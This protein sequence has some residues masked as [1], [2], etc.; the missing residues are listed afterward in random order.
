[1]EFDND[2]KAI[3]NEGS[4]LFLPSISVDCVIFGFHN[5]ELKVLL[6][7]MKQAGVYALPGGFILKGE[8][9]DTAAI[10]VLKE[11]TGLDNIFLQQFYTFGEPDRSDKKLHA[12]LMKKEGIVVDKTNWLLQ[13]FI[14]IGYYALVD[15]SAVSPKH[16]AL[17]ITCDWHTLDAVTTL[18]MDHNFILSKALQTLQQQISYLPIGYNLLPLKFTMPELQKLYETILNKSLDRRNF[19]RR[20]LSY[21]IIQKLTEVKTGVAHKAPFLYSFIE[22]KY[23]QALKNGLSG[24]W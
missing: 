9:A 10:R 6:L 23:N 19:Q 8:P 21:S 15:F 1:M 18:M 17:S 24:G 5:N 13:R 14:S 20:I 3:V 4:N 11:R 22:E 7:K 12:N 16:D 2:F